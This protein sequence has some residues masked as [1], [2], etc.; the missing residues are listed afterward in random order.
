MADI[1]TSVV[2]SAQIDGLRSGMEAAANSVQ[3][4]TDAMRSQLAGLGDIAEQ[5]QAQLNAATGQIG[6]GIRALQTK[7]ADFTGSLGVGMVPSGASDEKLR[8]EELVAYQ[9]FQSGKEQL[10]LRGVQTSQRTWQ[11]LM[12][13]IQRAFDTSITGMRLGTTTLQKA[14]AN[15]AQSIIAEFVNLGV[16]MVTNWIASELAMTTATEA[17]AAARTAADGGGMATG[18]AIKAANAIKSIA[19]DSA[20]AFSGIFAFLAP[21]MGPAAAGP[22]AAG[23]ATV[24]AAAS[25]IASA[26]GGWMVPS[27]QLAMVHQNEMILPANISQGLQNMISANGGPGAGAVVVNAS[28]IDS[29]DV[30]RF[31]QNNGSLL[32]NAVNKAMRNGS[33]L[34]TA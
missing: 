18:L 4:A 32:V 25:G 33:M 19:T 16:K 26:A 17:G 15:I 11:S 28:A 12:Q 31:F 27:D 5:A 30:K 8:E 3:A 1:E 29:Q 21:I 24:M 2:I 7:T 22:A 20:Q 23:E 34:R 10:D 13:P 9:K 14:V 6:N